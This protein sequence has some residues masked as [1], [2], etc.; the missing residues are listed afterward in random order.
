MPKNFYIF[1]VFLSIF[2]TAFSII[3]GL[4]CYSVRDEISTFGRGAN[5]PESIFS[6]PSQ[7]YIN[8]IFFVSKTIGN[9]TRYFVAFS[10]LV[11]L[12]HFTRFN[13]LDNKL[14]AVIGV[15]ASFT[16]FIWTNIM[17]NSP[18]H[19][20]FDEVFYVWIAFG[21]WNIYFS[22]AMIRKHNRLKSITTNSDILDN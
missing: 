11:F 15:L 2:F 7:P 4:L 6:L 17:Y 18:T 19:I 5:L 8:W 14:N 16:M 22:I 3:Y 1:F 20:S 12:L 13:R 10:E 21:I 9:Y